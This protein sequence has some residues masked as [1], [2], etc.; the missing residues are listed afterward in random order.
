VQT[1]GTT[2]YEKFSDADKQRRLPGKAPNGAL[3]VKDITEC[4]PW[5]YTYGAKDGIKQSLV[6]THREKNV[7]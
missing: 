2:P 6:H 7:K 3:Y 5:T 1:C 4:S